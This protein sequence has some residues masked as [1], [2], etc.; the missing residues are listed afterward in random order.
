MYMQEQKQKNNIILF[1]SGHYLIGS[2]IGMI[3]VIPPITVDLVVT[4]GK[5]VSSS[6]LDYIC[7]SWFTNM[8]DSPCAIPI[9]YIGRFTETFETFFSSSLIFVF[10]LIEDRHVTYVSKQQCWVLEPK[11]QLNP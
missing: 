1:S 8:L 3:P 7:Y 5:T 6:I 4:T 11:T 9:T 10:F 2:L